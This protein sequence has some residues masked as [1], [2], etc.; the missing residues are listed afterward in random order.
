MQ[1][2]ITTEVS[3]ED[4]SDLETVSDFDTAYEGV[5]VETLAD[6]GSCTQMA[7][8]VDI[9]S[10]NSGSGSVKSVPVG[11]NCN[12]TNSPCTSDSI[13]WPGSTVTLTA[14]AVKGSIFDGWYDSDGVQLTATGKPN[15][16]VM[17]VGTDD[18][19][20]TITAK[21]SK[22]VTITGYAKDVRGK[23]LSAATVTIF[24]DT[25]EVDDNY[26]PVYEQV[27]SPVRT[28]TKGLFTLKVS[29]GEDGEIVSYL[30]TVAKTGYSFSPSE[31]TVDVGDTDAGADE[32]FIGHVYSISGT[33]TKTN[34][35][36]DDV[37][38]PKVTVKL[39]VDTGE[40]DDNG[41][42]VY[43]TKATAKTNSKGTYVFKK[44]AVGDYTIQASSGSGASL[45]M[46]ETYVSADDFDYAENDVVGYMDI[47]IEPMEM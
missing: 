32:D 28:N 45:Y 42:P 46:G 38:A 11:I 14:P 5:L 29:P 44:V 43:K 26:D 27:G 12:L 16:Y 9:T 15:V 25:G 2:S 24:K 21:F 36:G 8:T 17:T 7:V 35:N 19:A 20:N 18:F 1:E 31:Q 33:V 34:S 37:A 23:G 47:Y 40:V 6:D 4:E 30:V 13:F 39:V 3:L 41:D 10:V 22:P